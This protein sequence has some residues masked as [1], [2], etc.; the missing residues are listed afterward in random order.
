MLA[1]E[2]KIEI[3]EKKINF[4]QEKEH[5]DASPKL[6][7]TNSIEIKPDTAFPMAW[8]PEIEQ[9]TH[10]FSSDLKKA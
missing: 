1:Q 8:I 6:F 9:E 7:L 3:L 10:E 4:S 2:N 5:C